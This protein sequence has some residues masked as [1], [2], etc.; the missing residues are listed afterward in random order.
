MKKIKKP[1]LVLSLKRNEFAE[2]WNGEKS[3]ECIGVKPYWTKRIGRWV[4][5]RKPHFVLFRPCRLKDEIFMIVRTLGVD[6]CECPY[7]GLTGKYY[8]IRL[9]TESIQAFVKEGCK[10]YPIFDRPK[11]I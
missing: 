2:I 6:I 7:R 1:D 11:M 10:Y 9:S 4:T 8:R 3:V 5:D